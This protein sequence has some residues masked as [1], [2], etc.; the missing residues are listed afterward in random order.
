MI[1]IEQLSGEIAALESERPTHVVMQKLAA[2]YTVRDH[3]LLDVD[4]MQSKADNL[5]IPEMMSDSEF[6]QAIRGKNWISVLNVMDELME[7]IQVLNPPLYAS[8]IRKIVG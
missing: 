7:A 8:V 4:T 1:S 6:S 5:V 3:L 2:L